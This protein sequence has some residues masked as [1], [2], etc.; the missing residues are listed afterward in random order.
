[1]H[2]CSWT[3]VRPE[4]THS[5]GRRLGVLLSPGE[6]VLLTGP[7]GAGKTVFAGG[8]LEGAGARGPFRSPTFTLVWEHD[9]RIPLYHVDLYRLAECDIEDDLP[10]EEI[11]GE[12]AAAVIEWAE[13]LPDFVLPSNRWEVNIER[14]PTDQRNISIRAYGR[15]ATALTEL[16]NG[17]LQHDDTCN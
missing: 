7:L 3:T 12:N 14:N 13:K 1:M 15:C 10:W 16:A 6:A 8:V 11:L 5:L 4:N 17:G 2:R 9:G